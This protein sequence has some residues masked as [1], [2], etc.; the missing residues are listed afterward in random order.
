MALRIALELSRSPGAILKLILLSLYYRI[1]F[2]I[3]NLSKYSRRRSPTSIEITTSYPSIPP[4]L[5]KT[6]ATVLF[7]FIKKNCI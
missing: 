3:Y 2:D 5:R 1:V 7:F 4:S 6:T